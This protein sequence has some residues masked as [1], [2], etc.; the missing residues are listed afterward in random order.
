MT[1]KSKEK[2]YLKVKKNKFYVTKIG[3]VLINQ[4]KKY[5]TNLV[6]YNFNSHIKKILIKISDN[7]IS[8]KNVLDVFLK[9]LLNNL[10]KQKTSRKRRNDK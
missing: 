9:I 6:D 3:K 2:G 8:W 10:N 5:F 1:T 4:L 7:K